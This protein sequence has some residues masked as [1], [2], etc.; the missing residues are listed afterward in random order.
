MF[1]RRLLSMVTNHFTI[2]FQEDGPD[3]KFQEDNSKDQTLV[4]MMKQFS[5]RRDHSSVKESN[6]FL[7]KH[8]STEI[9]H[10][11][12]LSQEDGPVSKFQVDNSKDQTLVSMMKLFL[13][14]K[15]PSSPRDLNMF[16]KKPQFMEI[17]HCTTLF[18]EDGLVNKFQEDNLKD[19]I[20]A[21]MMRLS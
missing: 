12:T 9:N 5:V 4:S 15:N 2:P 3:N 21:S 14:R 10:C 18:Q 11:T 13:A 8:P 20:L 7:R 16:Q 19:Q 6:M 17:N 1:Q